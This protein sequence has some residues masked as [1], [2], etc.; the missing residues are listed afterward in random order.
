MTSPTSQRP[1]A[2]RALAIVGALLALALAAIPAHAA[3]SDH[4][5]RTLR[6]LTVWLDWYPNSDHAGIYVAMARGYYAREGL[7][8]HAQVPSG[9]ADALRLVAHGSGDIAISYEPDILLARIQGVPV[10]AT[11]ALVQRPLNCIMTL[12][13]SGITRPRHLQGRTVGVAGLPGDDANIRSV[14]R[15]DGGN[16]ASVRQVS[17]NY[18]L[19]QALLARRVDAVEGVYWTWEALQARA[20]GHPVNVMR[21]DS[22]G[23]PSYDELVLATSTARLRAEPGV[24]HAFQRA[25]LAGYAYAAAHPAQAAA[26]VLRA[27]AVLSHDRALMVHSIRLL[28]PLYHDARGRYGTMSV[29]AWQ[30]Y[31]D[32]MFRT[33]LVRSR[34]DAHAALTTSLLP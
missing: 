26:I 5:P 19:L 11:A 13:S 10:I 22:Y 27:P 32:W 34:L 14:V 25:T 29:A 30:R 4:A 6:S 16:P 8:V 24:L 12:R 18:A 3:G 1:P 2:V 17:V 9:A 31:A 7:T 15:A 23:V 33:H 28:S 20:S 21:I